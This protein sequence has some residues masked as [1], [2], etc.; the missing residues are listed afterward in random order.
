MGEHYQGNFDQIMGRV[1]LGWAWNPTEPSHAVSVEL[2]SKGRILSRSAANLARDE[3]RADGIGMGRYGFALVVPEELDDGLPHDLQV[4]VAGQEQPLPGGT[5]LYQ[6][7]SAVDGPALPMPMLTGNGVRGQLDAMEDAT[8]HGW[9]MDM[10]H[11]DAAVRLALYDGERFVASAVAD[12]RRDDV[13]DAGIGTGRYGFCLPLPRGLRDGQSHWLNLRRAGDADNLLPMALLYRAGAEAAIDPVPAPAPAPAPVAKRQKPSDG[14]KGKL[15][16]PSKGK[17]R[18]WVW[19]SRRPNERLS[20]ELLLDGVVIATTVADKARP[21]L[22]ALGI[23][24]GRYGIELAIPDTAQDGR[25]HS[26]SYRLVD[27]G[28]R[29]GGASLAVDM[30]ARAAEAPRKAPPASRPVKSKPAAA[31]PGVGKVDGSIDLPGYLAQP[32][33]I[34]RLRALPLEHRVSNLS[35]MEAGRMVDRLVNRL[36]RE[37]MA[38]VAPAAPARHATTLVVLVAEGQAKAVAYSLSVWALQSQPDTHLVLLPETAAAAREIAGTG[39]PLLD[40]SDQD[41]WRALCRDSLHV[42]FLR[43]GDCL[44]P[45]LASILARSTGDAN[46][47][48]WNLFAPDHDPDKGGWLYRRP[49]MDAVTACHAA[50]VDTGFAVRGA[51]LAS[52]PPD[53]LEAVAR[54]NPHLALFWLA[55]RPE[56]VWHN[57]PEALTSRPMEG[58]PD[59]RARLEQDLDRYRRLGRS[60]EPTFSLEQTAQ[61]VPIPFVLL[62]ARRARRISVLICYR[63]HAAMTLRCLH[64]IARQRITGSLE[65]VLVDNQSQPD[66]QA[67]VLKG[68]RRLFKTEDIVPVR[69]D[70]PFNHSAQNNAGA[71]VATGEVIVICN[72]DM[73]LRDDTLLEEIAAWALW[74]GI[75]TVSCQIMNTVGGRG[76]YGHRVLPVRD[77]PYAPVLGENDDPTYRGYLRPTPGNSLCLGA[78]ARDRYLAAGGLDAVQFPIGYNDVDF[79]LRCRER[80]MTHLYLGHLRADHERGASRT[81]DN[82]DLQTLWIRAAHPIVTTERLFQAQKERLEPGVSARPPAKAAVP[83]AVSPD[84]G[85][86]Q[87]LSARRD[88]ERRR[89]RL[90]EM[91]AETAVDLAALHR[92]LDEL[93]GALVAD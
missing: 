89:A 4:R 87:V 57:H 8:L 91:V 5:K 61:D 82:E 70:A 25:T 14:F 52:M 45:S 58:E 21:D 22:V 26:L 18:G 39:A 54:G 6:R 68:A 20:V 28:Y 19:D 32:E 50:Y 17:F 74:D 90:T 81:G 35:R 78:M 75:G 24:D 11:P 63:D 85:A 60:L 67:Q 79:A 77:D 13:R 44:H 7:S 80:G 73:V 34:D 40:A 46:V 51:H 37:R 72:N 43:A 84:D 3:L 62:P 86:R 15:E 23:G 48:V 92:R 31:A 2:V 69:Y 12:R 83:P 1:A 41:G 38:A 42:T 93:K 76:A 71:Q 30:P 49:R 9:A 64:S 27:G 33:Q 55:T 10:E 88:D 59:R 53:I 56:T 36:K 29:F 65:I 47:T 66:E 16:K